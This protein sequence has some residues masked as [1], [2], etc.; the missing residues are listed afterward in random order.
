VIY[1]RE[2]YDWIEA[3]WA[4]HLH[5]RSAFIS[6]EDFSQLK[7]WEAEGVPAELIVGAMETFFERRAKRPRPKS[8]I[9]L[10]QL[11]K[12]VAKSMKLRSALIRSESEPI[13]L[14]GWDQVKAP[15]RQDPKARVLFEAWR[16][17]KVVVPFP[18]APHFLECFDAERQAFGALIQCAE[19][20]LNQQL[21]SMRASLRERLV[22]A[23]IKP[24]SIVWKRAWNHHWSRTVAEAWKISMD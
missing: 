18:D 24:D 21:E 6:R 12:D 11:E 10:S 22:E 9:A 15:L 14:E 20:A 4:F 17:A 13:S 3:E 19:L 1:S 2:E 8:F 16:R 23:Q 7:T 5:G